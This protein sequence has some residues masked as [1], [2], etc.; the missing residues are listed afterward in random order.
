MKHL[1]IIFLIAIPSVLFSQNTQESSRGTSGSNQP[2]SQ[3]QDT[4]AKPPITLYKMISVDRDTIILDTSLTIQKE[5][6]FNYL[7]KD[8]FELLPFNNVGQTYNSLARDIKK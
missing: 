4:A 8:N 1:L 7:R 5:Y 2:M 6:K 3:Q